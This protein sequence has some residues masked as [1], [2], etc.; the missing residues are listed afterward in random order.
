[1]GR[2]DLVAGRRDAGHAAVVG[3]SGGRDFEEGGPLERG[4]GAGGGPGYRSPDHA[5]RGSDRTGTFPTWGKERRDN[6]L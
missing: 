5:C 2:T 3:G 4:H 1:M 6:V